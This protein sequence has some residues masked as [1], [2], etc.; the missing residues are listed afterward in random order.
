[1]GVNGVHQLSDCWHSAKYLHYHLH[2]L[3]IHHINWF[4]NN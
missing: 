3:H 2:H 1:M 4:F